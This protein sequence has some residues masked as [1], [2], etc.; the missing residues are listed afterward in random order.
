MNPVFLQ[1]GNFSL[2]W[3]SLFILI[4]V[5][6][7]TFFIIKEGKRFNLTK[8]FI[9]N[10]LFWTILVGI[11]GARIYYVA[12]SWDYYS[13]NPDDIFKIWEGGLAIHGGI[14]FGVATI[15]IYCKRYKVNSVRLLDIVIPYML[16]SQALGRWGNFFNQEAHGPVT[17]LETLKNLHIPEFIING[18]YINGNYYMPTFLYESIWCIFGFI[19]LIII[20]RHKYIRLGQQF[21]IYLLWYSTFRFFIEMYR[22]DS[23]MFNGFKV[24]QL[25]SIVLF[26]IGLAIVLIQSRKPRLE[27]LYNEESTEEL[28]F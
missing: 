7:S 14:I 23:L 16:F 6:I 4:A 22:Q 28:R 15:I 10:L 13:N 1:I 12:F 18:M 5:V 20:R 2:R 11:I 26:I 17:S 25:V 21:G 27:E 24:A 9:I 8:D 3:Y 19:L